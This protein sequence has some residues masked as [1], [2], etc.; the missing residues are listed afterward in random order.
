MLLHG[1]DDT[2]TLSLCPTSLA[3]TNQETLHERVDSLRSENEAMRQESE[4]LRAQQDQ[5]GSQSR[6]LDDAHTQH[7]IELAGLRQELLEASHQRDE[8]QANLVR[9]LIKAFQFVLP[10]LSRSHPPAGKVGGSHWPASAGA[11]DC[12]PPVG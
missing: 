1:V 4:V 3:L 7:A 8:A 5:Y 2:H 11:G 9:S 10:S 12:R 6:S